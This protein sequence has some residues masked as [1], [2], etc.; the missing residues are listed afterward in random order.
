[1]ANVLYNEA[2]DGWNPNRTIRKFEPSVQYGLEDYA[3]DVP[4]Q[5]DQPPPKLNPVKTNVSWVADDSCFLPPP[6]TTVTSTAAPEDGS[7]SG[8]ATP[9]A[10]VPGGPMAGGTQST[11]FALL[12]LVSL[13]CSFAKGNIL[14]P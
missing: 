10:A 13:L 3:I 1:M 7:T 9:S 11:S 2:Y 6:S 14:W 12:D 5:A 8:G 4:F